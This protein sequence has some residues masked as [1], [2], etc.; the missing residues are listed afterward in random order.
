MLRHKHWPRVDSN[1]R[2]PSILERD[3]ITLNILEE[4]DDFKESSNV[5]VNIIILLF[6]FSRQI[7]GLTLRGL[8][9]KARAK[10]PWILL[11]LPLYTRW[12]FSC[13][14]PRVKKSDLE[15]WGRSNCSSS[16]LCA[17][18]VQLFSS[19]KQGASV[20]PPVLYKTQTF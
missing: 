12:L 4:N 10:G 20:Q 13:E 19:K 1:E 17:P 11:S 6:F 9:V 7:E 3:V 5:G 8:I 14:K 16:S 2:L 15:N 18:P